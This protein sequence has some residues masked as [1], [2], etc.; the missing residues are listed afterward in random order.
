MISKT[1]G[2]VLLIGAAVIGATPA[3]AL[4]LISPADTVATGASRPIKV[5]QRPYDPSA[6]SV[7]YKKSKAQQVVERPY[8]PS[9]GSVGYKKGKKKKKSK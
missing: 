8:D 7:G 4:S 9:A 3:G 1:T 6:G 2:L 5:A